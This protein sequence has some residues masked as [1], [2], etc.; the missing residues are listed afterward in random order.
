VRTERIGLIATASTTYNEP[1]ELARRFA[2]LDHISHGRVGWNIVTTASADAARNFGLE[3]HALHHVRYQRA[4]EFLDVVTKLWDSWEDDAALGDKDAGL[5]ADAARIH[6]IDHRGSFFTVAGPLDVPRSPQGWPLLVQAGSSDDGRA[7]AGRHAE[8]VFTA[9]RTL[10]EGQSFYA[11]VKRQAA[12]SGRSPG[13]I[14]ILPGIV[15]VIGSTEAEARAREQ[16]FDDQ[17]IPAYRLRQLSKLFGV[18]LTSVDLDAPLPEVPA[19]DEIEGSKSR[20]A[21]VAELARRERLTVRELL[22]R[23]GGGRGHRSFTGTPEQLADD[24]EQWFTGGAADGFN[25]MAPALPGDLETF[26]EHVIPILRDRGLFR[27]A[28]EG[29]TLRGHYGL[30]RPANRLAGDQVAA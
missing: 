11:D 14:L 27:T 23:L 5:F 20:S 7:F 4:D 21:L 3:D 26:I 2:S 15:P 8:A 18:D 1:Y 22:A 9:Q 28:Y 19:Q 29:V 10:A 24:L 17:I 13:E 16:L 12:L 30:T 25:V 6:R